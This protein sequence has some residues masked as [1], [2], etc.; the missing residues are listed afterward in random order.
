MHGGSNRTMAP[1]KTL[2]PHHDQR[3]SENVQPVEHGKDFVILVITLLP[4]LHLLITV[5]FFN[6]LHL[7][8]T[9]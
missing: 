7:V 3:T 1:N 8:S 6:T 9:V 5:A 4:P 2:L